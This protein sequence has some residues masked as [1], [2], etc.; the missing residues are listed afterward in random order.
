MDIF[1]NRGTNE[2]VRNSQ[3]INKYKDCEH[4]LRI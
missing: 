4:L 3:K 2:V 1:I